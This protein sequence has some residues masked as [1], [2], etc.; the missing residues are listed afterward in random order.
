MTELTDIKEWL[1]NELN[2]DNVN[3]VPELLLEKIFKDREGMFDSYLKLVGNDL[4]T[5]YLQKFYQYYLSDRDN[6][7]QDYT[8]KSLARLVSYLAG[9]E[10]DISDVCCGSGALTIQKWVDNK[11]IRVHLYELDST[12]IPFLIFNMAVRKIPSIIYQGNVLSQKIEKVYI[13][14]NGE[15][16]NG[17]SDI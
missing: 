3:K 9:E 2:T 5:D 8:P 12:V 7:G 10:E 1:F 15:V 14:S 4:E 11:N 17:S 6:L 16:K 13:I